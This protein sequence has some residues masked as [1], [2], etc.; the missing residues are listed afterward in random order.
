MTFS[1]IWIV[2]AVFGKAPAYNLPLAKWKY[3]IVH[4][5]ATLEIMPSMHIWISIKWSAQKNSPGKEM[6]YCRLRWH[7][8][9]ENRKHHK[10]VYFSLVVRQRVFW[11]Y[12]LPGSHKWL[13]TDRT[14]HKWLK[15]AWIMQNVSKDAQQMVSNSNRVTNT[16]F[17]L[18]FIRYEFRFI[19]QRWFCSSMMIHLTR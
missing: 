15:I 6:H 9:N 14:G 3:S 13:S 11:L 4:R 16:L 1:L 10:R 8:R 18:I 7:E 2:P 12:A 19:T 17:Q 5:K